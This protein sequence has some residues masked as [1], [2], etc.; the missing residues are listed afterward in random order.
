VEAD[1]LG[2]V[3]GGEAVCAADADMRNEA[4]PGAILDPPGRAAEG[5]GDLLGTVETGQGGLILGAGTVAHEGR[6]HRGVMQG[7]WVL[8]RLGGVLGQRCRTNLVIPC[9]SSGDETLCGAIIGRPP[10][11]ILEAFSRRLSR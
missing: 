8:T 11:E 2:E 9:S 6:G 1:D 7:K 3:F 10:S 5:F 4:A